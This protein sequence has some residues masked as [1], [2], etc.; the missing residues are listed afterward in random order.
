MTKP[1]LTIG[2][3]TWNRCN[4]I[5]VAIDSV[6]DQLTDDLYPLIEIL[7]SDNASTDAT[8]LVMA[9]YQVKHPDLFSLNRN[10]ENLGFSRNVDL[11]FRLA[12]GDFALVL[13]DDDALEPDAIRE[14]F[15]A[16]KQHETIDIMVVLASEYTDT[17]SS[18]IN[19]AAWAK[20]RA[21]NNNVPFCAYYPSGIEYFKANGSLCHVCISGNLFRVSA[22]RA[23]D[24]AA[25]LASGSVQLHAAVQLHAKGSSCVI[26]RPLIRYRSG[27]NLDEYNRKMR[28]EGYKAGYPFAYHFDVIKAC[29]GG[30]GLYPDKVYRGFYLICVRGV[31]YTLLDV[32]AYNFPMD[33]DYFN[34]RLNDCFDHDYCGWLIPAF[35]ILQ[36]LPAWTFVLPDRLY[37][38]GRKWYLWLSWV[39]GGTA[40]KKSGKLADKL[41]RS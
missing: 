39:R 26:K 6:L 9:E 1:L 36:R 7:V 40:R 33:K 4:D 2:I 18:P 20:A 17:L 22:W 19:P 16:L 23:V 28:A 32:K 14:I 13:S 27:A 24:M 10:T 29:R 38:V 5:R 15:R 37:K 30:K 3:P 31:F 12:K 35:R 41:T 25:G 11:L 8:P 34:F 21:V